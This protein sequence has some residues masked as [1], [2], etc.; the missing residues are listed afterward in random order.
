MT[1]GATYSLRY[2][3]AA[4]AAVELTLLLQKIGDCGDNDFG[5]FFV[6]QM[7]AIVDQ[8]KL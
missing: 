5:P 6:R 8:D 3:R 7:P 4:V 1:E 2:A